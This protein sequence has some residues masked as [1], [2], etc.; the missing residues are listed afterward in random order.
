MNYFEAKV[1]V[2]STDVPAPGKAGQED[3][4]LT[5]GDTLPDPYEPHNGHRRACEDEERSDSIKRFLQIVETS[6]PPQLT[7]RQ[8]VMFKLRYFLNK[9]PK[10][11]SEE[12]ETT[13]NNVNATLA[14]AR[15][16]VLEIIDRELLERIRETLNDD[17]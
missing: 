2:V 5:P 17:A 3:D 16:R 8:R 4:D 15:T 13:V 12:L 7:P 9:S 14:Q 10:D 6:I 11:I 1:Q